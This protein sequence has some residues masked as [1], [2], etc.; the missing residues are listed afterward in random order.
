LRA[1]ETAAVEA[2]T[3]AIAAANGTEMQSAQ[4]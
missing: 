2:A 4:E 3:A 1:D